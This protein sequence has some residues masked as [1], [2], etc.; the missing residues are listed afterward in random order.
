MSEILNITSQL[1]SGI[2]Y[3]TI[4][5]PDK[6]NALNNQTLTELGVLLKKANDDEEVKGVII[7]GS[8]EKA[9]IAG[10]DIQEISELNE[11]NARKFAEQGQEIF[12][13]IENSSKPIVAAINGFALGGGCELAMACHLRLAVSHAKFGLPEVNL[14]IIPGFGGTQRLTQL[15]GK[16][17]AMEMMMTGDMINAQ[18]ALSFGMVNHITDSDNLIEQATQ[19]VQKILKKAPLAI[20]QVIE[21]VNAAFI[22]EEDGFQTEAKSFGI[23]CKS[24]DFVEGTSAFLEKRPPEF[25][26]K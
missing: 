14:G 8:G 20:A 7:T 5:R 21:C 3:L 4:N 1:T 25:T 19:L 12:S 22:A 26:G 6:L 11:L 18:T 2:F 17:R 15:I 16:G 23:L 10:A 24:K 9:F 13:M